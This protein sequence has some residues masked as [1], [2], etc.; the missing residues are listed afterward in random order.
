[1][2]TE[3]IISEFDKNKIIFKSLLEN[4]PHD[5]YL[6]REKE[7]KWN[8]LELVCHL[9]DEERDDFRARVQSVLENPEA[10]LKP[11]D[12][13][14]WVESRKYSKENYNDK[15]N[16]FINERDNSISYLKNLS[17]AKWDNAYIHEKFG[18][19]T[20]G[21]F[22]ASWLAHDYLHIRQIIRIKY[23][24]LKNQSG[25]NLLYAGEL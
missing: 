25:E 15:L 20:A 23:E 3:Q 22:L 9:Y 14:G 12:P 6:F 10:D 19:L 8:L 13:E 11:I 24:Y 1:M 17:A 21:M 7:G 5:F 18:P 16:D 4:L 2:N